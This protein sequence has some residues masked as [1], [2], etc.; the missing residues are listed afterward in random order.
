MFSAASLSAIAKLFS[1]TRPTSRRAKSGGRAAIMSSA[2]ATFPAIRTVFTPK[3]RTVSSKSSA[4]RG[5]SSTIK[6]SLGSRSV[7]AGSMI[8][9]ITGVDTLIRPARG[10]SRES[11][12]AGSRNE[13]HHIAVPLSVHLCTENAEMIRYCCTWTTRNF[14]RWCRPPDPP[15]VPGGPTTI[16]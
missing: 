12:P 13:T 2:I 16:Y 9:P 8:T 6:T 11:A 7:G 5:S 4:I 15:P 10:R 1:R 14:S 3:P